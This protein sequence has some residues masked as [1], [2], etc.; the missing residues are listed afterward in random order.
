LE[1]IHLET[2]KGLTDLRPLRAAPALR[3]LELVD[4][5]QLRRLSRGEL[6]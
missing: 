5:P 6:D 4:M 3:E 2:M 1:R